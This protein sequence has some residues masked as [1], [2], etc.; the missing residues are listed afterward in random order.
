M[1]DLPYPAMRINLDVIYNRPDTQMAEHLPP[2]VK[3]IKV[4]TSFFL[5]QWNG[6]GWEGFSYTETDRHWPAILKKKTSETTAVIHFVCKSFD[7]EIRYT[8]YDPRSG[9]YV[10]QNDSLWDLADA[11]G[12][13]ISGEGLKR[14]VKQT[15][16]MLS[17]FITDLML[18]SN[19][20][21][22]ITPVRGEPRS[23]EWT[24]ARTHYTIIYH[25]HPAN[26]PTVRSGD[27]V[28]VDENET[29]T[30]MA[31]ARRAHYK[32]LRHDRYRFMRGQ[33]VKVKACWVGPK[34]WKDAG[35][36]QIYRLLEAV[37]QE[38]AA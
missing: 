28:R 36:R 18:P 35:G 34:E 26:R 9:K 8:L 11:M 32:T 20:V 13:P 10:R 4:P 25:D 37:G 38:A 22:E 24:K 3:T 33:R 29:L 1:E 21:A 16:L 23:V 31:H 2:Q 17:T 19:R 14:S 27:R 5:R 7:D 30:R 12:E 6:T 15:L